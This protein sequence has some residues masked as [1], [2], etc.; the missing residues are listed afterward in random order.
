[1]RDLSDLGVAHHVADHAAKAALAHFEAGVTTTR[2][3]D[4]SPVT[5]ADRDVERLLRTSL[6]EL[7][8][9]DALLGEEL[10]QEGSSER[11]WILDPIDG[12]SFFSR[13]DP[14]WR[15]HVALEVDGVTELAV[16]TAPALGLR[17]WATRDGGAFESVWPTETGH[18]RRLAVSTTSS[19]ADAAV[20][21]IDGS[22]SGRRPAGFRPASTP[23]PLVELVRGEIDGVLVEGYYKWDHAPWVL[24][25][26]EAGGRFTDPCGGT[27][28]DQG[29]GIYSNEALHDELLP[30]VSY[31]RPS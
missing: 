30:R 25:V 19:F 4:G 14:N 8:P 1:M 23:L 22:A 12:T 27:A 24:L 16:V 9:G 6:T 26:Q 5:E 31:P 15:V 29:G 20:E 2:K 18:V 7:R 13:R 28:A 21:S 3:A 10:G 17:W 11:V